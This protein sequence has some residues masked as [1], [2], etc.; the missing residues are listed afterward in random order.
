VVASEIKSQINML[1]PRHNKTR[2]QCAFSP[3]PIRIPSTCQFK[4]SPAKSFHYV[5]KE[6]IDKKSLAFL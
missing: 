6:Y 2:G 4:K 1:S 3:F 5:L